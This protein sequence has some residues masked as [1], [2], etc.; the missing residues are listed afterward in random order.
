MNVYVVCMYVRICMRVDRTN[1]RMFHDMIHQGRSIYI[2]GETRPFYTLSWSRNIEQ[3][4]T[5]AV[6][7][8]AINSFRSCDTWNIAS[9]S[10]VCCP[11]VC[12]MQLAIMKQHDYEAARTRP[13]VALGKRTKCDCSL[14]TFTH[15]PIHS[16][17]APASRTSSKQLQAQN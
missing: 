4:I 11:E 8:M 15:A 13:S 14:D 17:Q 3:Q 16:R 10:E 7:L 2:Y 9:H 1:W 5:D 12:S 6:V